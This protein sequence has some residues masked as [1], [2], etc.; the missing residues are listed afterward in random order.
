MKSKCFLSPC[1]VL[2]DAVEAALGIISAR[3]WQV[4]SKCL[5]FIGILWA[6]YWNFLLKTERKHFNMHNTIFSRT[7]LLLL[8]QTSQFQPLPNFD[9]C[10]FFILLLTLTVK[11]DIAQTDFVWLPVLHS[12][13]PDLAFSLLYTLAWTPGHGPWLSKEVDKP[14][15]FSCWP[16]KQ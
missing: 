15:V 6:W 11:I 14:Q 10:V 16:Q 9:A 8:L 1:D 2:L 7:R 12:L 4:E 3:I 13:F 5:Q